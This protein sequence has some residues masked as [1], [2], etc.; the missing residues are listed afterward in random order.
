MHDHHVNL[1][2]LATDRIYHDHLDFTPLRIWVLFNTDLHSNRIKHTDF[3]VL[4]TS[5]GNG[6]GVIL[7]IERMCIFLE[8]NESFQTKTTL[9]AEFIVGGSREGLRR[10][11]NGQSISECP[12][13]ECFFY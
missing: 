3:H 1:Q 2:T 5:S 10:D 7:R 8:S 4:A 11:E 9:S 12:D 6:D 13:D